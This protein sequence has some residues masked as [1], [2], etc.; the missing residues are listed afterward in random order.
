MPGN[1]RPWG[2]L[3]IQCA[4]VTGSLVSMLAIYAA[5][6][7]WLAGFFYPL[8]FRPAISRQA[9]R[10]NLDP[11]FVAAVIRQESGFRPNARSAAGAIGLMQLM[12]KT[13]V[14]AGHQLGLKHFQ[15]KDLENPEVN[16]KV[17]CWYLHHLFQ[18]FRDPAM[19]LA[20]YNGGEGNLDYWSS[21]HGDRLHQAFPET[22]S[23]VAQG[24]RTYKRYQ[25]LY[26]N[27]FAR[28]TAIR[29]FR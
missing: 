6:L 5:D 3:A 18:Q 19:V 13:A 21:I 24:L 14:W 9:R 2:V 10:W 27:A 8:R 22:Q 28:V 7:P 23:Y 12:P 11:L 16:I 20:A 15:V 1:A 4:A 25:A 29:I 17:G 26:P